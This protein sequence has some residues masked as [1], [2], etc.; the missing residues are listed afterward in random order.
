MRRNNG[1]EALR[2]ASG[3]REAPMVKLKPIRGR[4]HIPAKLITIEGTQTYG[5]RAAEESIDVEESSS[6]PM[7]YSA[8]VPNG[9]GRSPADRNRRGSEAWKRQRI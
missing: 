7:I 8:S 5:D 3:N 1:S 4:H 9:S 6:E 2:Q